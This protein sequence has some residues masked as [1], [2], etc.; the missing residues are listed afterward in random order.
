MEVFPFLS[1]QGVY[2]HWR[3]R[4]RQKVEQCWTFNPRTP[5]GFG[6]TPTPGGMDFRPP[7]LTISKA[8]QDSD[9]W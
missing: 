3:L 2:A 9:K 6:R 1:F 7:P 5:V 8:E 4:G